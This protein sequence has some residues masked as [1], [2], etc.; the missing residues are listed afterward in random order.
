MSRIIRMLTAVTAAGGLAAFGLM[1]AGA[2]SAASSP[3]TT[4]SGSWSFDPGTGHNAITQGGTTTVHRASVLQPINADGSSV[5]NHKSSTIPVQFQVQSD[6]Q[7]TPSVYPGLLESSASVLYGNLQYTPSGSPTVADISNLEADFT[8]LS[9][10]QDEGGSL[11]WQIDTPIGNMNL[12]YGDNPSFQTDLNGTDTGVNMVSLASSSARVDS[13]GMTGGSYGP[14]TWTSTVAQFGNEPVNSVALIVDSGAWEGN[15]QQ[16]QLVDANVTIGTNTS[17]YTPGT[18]GSTSDTGW[19]NDNSASA[20]ISLSKTSG[21]TPAGAIDETTLTSTQGDTGG[22]F[23]QVDGKYIYNLPVSN[24]PD[25]TAT[26]SVGVSFQSDGS[27]P[28]P[29]I[30]HFGLR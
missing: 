27:S 7:T 6:T 25:S 8:W 3:G 16:V 12:Y 24:L 1:T 5:F 10:Q 23:R 18:V 11:R 20:W 28:V 13:S 22:Q 4:G 19:V 2:A 14:N 30:A 21:A 26:Y 15:T 29:V 17:S 9:A